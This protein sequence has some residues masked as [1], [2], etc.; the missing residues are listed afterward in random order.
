MLFKL[1]FLKCVTMVVLL[2][3]RH[4]RK[5]KAERAAKRRQ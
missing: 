1:F 3:I 4:L 5:T 2:R